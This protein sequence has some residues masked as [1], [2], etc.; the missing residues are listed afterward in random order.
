MTSIYEIRDGVYAL[1]IA[2]ERA[3]AVCRWRDDGESVVGVRGV[4]PRIPKNI[5]K[6]HV[7]K[8]IKATLRF[9]SEKANAQEVR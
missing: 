8:A 7:G 3:M 9:L 2:G 5:R 6:V 1:G 4:R